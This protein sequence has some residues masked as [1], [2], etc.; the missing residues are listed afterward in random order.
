MN[1]ACWW[2]GMFSKSYWTDVTFSVPA[3]DA[4]E[5]MWL[6]W[7]FEWKRRTQD[8]LQCFYFTLKIVWFTFTSY[9]HI[10]IVEYKY[11]PMG[12]LEVHYC[13][14]KPCWEEYKQYIINAPSVQSEWATLFHF[15]I[16]PPNEYGS[17]FS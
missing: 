3:E 9:F 4:M 6:N 1:S 16:I 10:L 12:R 11:F 14:Q 2:S 5:R 13:R 17:C 15:F 8:S 7:R